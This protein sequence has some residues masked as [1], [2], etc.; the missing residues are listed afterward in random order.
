MIE[1]RMPIPARAYNSAVGGHVCGPE[2]VDF[3]QKVV[4]LVKYDRSGN[5]VS[6][7]S[8]VTQANKIYV[9]HDDFT[10][11]S[12]V[13]IPANCVLEF[14]GGSLSGDNI[15]TL[16][17]TKINGAVIINVDLLGTISN[18]ELYKTW[19]DKIT[20]FKGLSLNNKKI[21]IDEN[22][23][24]DEEF[25]ISNT[26]DLIIDGC[27]CSHQTSVD[28][29]RVSG[30]CYN[31]EICNFNITGTTESVFFS[32]KG[33]GHHL[34]YIDIHDCHLNTFRVG[35]SLDATNTTVVEN[36]FNHGNIYN[37]Y[38]DL[39]NNSGE[40]GNYGIHISN[41]NYV[42]VF[43]NII[44]GCVRHAIYNAWGSYN[45]IYDN[46]I[47]NN[48]TTTASPG[49]KIAIFRDSRHIVVRNNYFENNIGN[50]IGITGMAYDPSYTLPL[51]TK[52]ID[53]IVEN[54]TIISNCVQSSETAYCISLGHL[55]YETENITVCDNKI[56][57]TGNIEGNTVKIPFNINKLYGINKIINNIIEIEP[58]AD[59]N[60][61]S[62]Q[63]FKF[64]TTSNP[65]E[66]QDF[67]T[68]MYIIQGNT[69][70]S[71]KKLRTG[72][73]AIFSFTSRGEALCDNIKKN[74][75]ILDNKFINYR[76]QS[77]V[78]FDIYPYQD[79]DRTIGGEVDPGMNRYPMI[80]SACLVHTKVTDNPSLYITN[81]G[82][83]TGFYNRKGD[84]I[85]FYSPTSNPATIGYKCTVSGNPGTWV[86][87]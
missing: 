85:L 43:N 23:I 42:N 1:H 47:V 83:N 51:S 44:T 31:I 30:T 82:I 9:I 2:D 64:S 21:L 63:C 7:E 67:D 28:I 39:N 61:L 19:V 52:P 54:N 49:A 60:T 22:C 73:Y 18:Y 5:E 72:G 40:I 50:D 84:I 12:N 34:S 74:V 55:Q 11:S 66:R 79:D 24:F 3:G 86:S 53:I 6:F 37:N 41:A 75:V 77:D 59:N 68:G 8:Q 71:T 10:L 20:R 27:N 32:S 26:H 65:S 56:K 46:R 25:E 36:D 48:G 38:I 76:G 14:D 70:S 62:P 81:D 29:W 45:N 87:F 16:S 80:Q 4:H 57:V 33:H 35:I 15:I 13:T 78:N 58:D 69:I 17:N